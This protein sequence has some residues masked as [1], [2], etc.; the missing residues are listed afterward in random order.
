MSPVQLDNPEAV[1]GKRVLVVEDGPTTTHG[2]MPYGAGYVAAIEAGALE[3]VD[4]RK[5]AVPE[6][7]AVYQRYPHIGFVLPA[8]GYFPA[9]LRALQDTINRADVDVV[10]TATPSN[11]GALIQVNKPLIRARYEFAEAEQPG[12]TAQIE[13]FLRRVRIPLAA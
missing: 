5:F 1:S 6:I 9:Q 12:L 13:Q 10:V 7:A 3:I 8:M 2:G 4:P 11:L